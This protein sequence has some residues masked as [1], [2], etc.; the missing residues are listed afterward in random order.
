MDLEQKPIASFDFRI[1]GRKIFISVESLINVLEEN[2]DVDII[3]T[4][5]SHVHQLQNHIQQLPMEK[6]FEITEL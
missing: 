1:D 3:E 4:V 6:D 5:K 2:E